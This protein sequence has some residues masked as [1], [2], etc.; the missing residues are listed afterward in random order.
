VDNRAPDTSFRGEILSRRI[1]RDDQ[2][3]Y[4][5][6]A[7]AQKLALAPLAFHAALALRDLGLLSALANCG[8]EGL[9]AERLAHLTHLPL[10]GV[11]VLLEAGMVTDLIA[12]EKDHF[13]LRKIGLLVQQD[14]MTRA[15]MDFTADV[16]YGGMAHLRE[17]IK[18]GKPAGL[19]ELGPWATIYEGLAH[20]PPHVQQS[21]FAFDH[22]YSDDLFPA[23]LPVV[24]ERKPSR[25]LDVGAN[26]GKFS[27]SCLKHNADVKVTLLDH[28]GQL[29]IAKQSIDA[30]GQGARATYQPIDFLDRSA[31]FPEK[32]D[33]IWLS[34]FLD[35]FGEDEIVSI[36]QRARRALAPNGRIYIV[37]TYWDNQEHAAAR[38]VLVMTT[39]YFT[40]LAN[41]NSK[42]YH[43]DDMRACVKRSGL[44]IEREVDDLTLSHTMFVCV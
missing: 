35:C 6:K 40:C 4:E 5:A 42:M 37:D 19:K 23:A 15:N 36:L 39:L 31:E 41:G 8:P 26:T 25:L 3:L 30:S 17:A 32:F 22:Y 21:W 43:S 1:V 2:S 33:A 20:L 38:F 28:S 16:C 7:D 12:L 11:K 29:N 27:L 34:Q 10:Y 44:K 24:F 18:T 14:A 9:T 13:R